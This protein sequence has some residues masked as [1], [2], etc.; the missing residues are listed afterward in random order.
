MYWTFGFIISLIIFIIIM[1]L[2][3]FKAGRDVLEE[4]FSDTFLGDCLEAF[5]MFGE[6]NETITAGMISLFL[7]FILL[8]AFSLLFFFVIWIFWPLL[9]AFAIYYGIFVWWYKNK[10][11][12]KK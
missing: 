9:V 3:F 8:L 12:K 7:S 1:G 4:M 10:I 5:R 6:G 11:K 2:L